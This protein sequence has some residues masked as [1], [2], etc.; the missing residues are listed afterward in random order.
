MKKTLF[1]VFALV[2]ALTAM[3]FHAP[4]TAPGDKVLTLVMQVGDVTYK[5]PASETGDMIFSDNGATLNIRGREYKVADITSMSVA[6]IEPEPVKLVAIE[7]R[8]GYEW[9]EPHNNIPLTYQYIVYRDSVFSDGSVHTMESRSGKTSVEW[10]VYF[11]PDGKE[12]QTLDDV[13]VYYFDYRRPT[14]DVGYDNRPIAWYTKMA[15]PDLSMLKFELFDGGGYT[16]GKPGDWYRYFQRGQAWNEESPT[17]GWYWTD[18]GYS[19][20]GVTYVPHETL[21]QSMDVI[22]RFYDHF[23]YV[24]DDLNGGQRIDFLEYQMTYDFHILEEDT[25]MP[26]GEPAKVCTTECF[27]DFLG[28]RFRIAAVD[29]VYQYTTPPL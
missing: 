10:A 14:D 13:T 16:H 9:Y 23:L 28:K 5:I 17:V 21:R 11:V 22:P 8:K 12:K 6:E 4:G 25:T 2:L 26:T 20:E 24:E 18:I 3:G 27:M 15:V 19:R 1:L 29:T 7:Y